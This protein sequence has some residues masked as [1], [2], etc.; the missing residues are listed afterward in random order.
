MV[1]ERGSLDDMQELISI[2]GEETLRQTFRE[3][4]AR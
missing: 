1:M 2:V 3:A 4:D